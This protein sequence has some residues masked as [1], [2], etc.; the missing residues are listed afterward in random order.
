MRDEIATELYK[1]IKDGATNMHYVADQILALRCGG[2]KRW[3]CND[4]SHENS[5]DAKEKGYGTK[6]WLGHPLIEIPCTCDNGERVHHVMWD[7]SVFSNLNGRKLTPADLV[8]PDVAIG[9][10]FMHEEGMK[11][12]ELSHNKGTLRLQEGK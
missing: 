10:A 9:Y 6:C 7:N 12:F 2:S 4:P 5:Y 8:D 11:S 3:T 1:Q